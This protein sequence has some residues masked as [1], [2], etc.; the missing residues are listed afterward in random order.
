MNIIFHI[1]RFHLVYIKLH[2]D[3]YA[4]EYF[5]NCLLNDD[6]YKENGIKFAGNT[7]LSCRIGNTT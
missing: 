6:M 7:E 2:D 1:K 4:K 3:E 5:Y